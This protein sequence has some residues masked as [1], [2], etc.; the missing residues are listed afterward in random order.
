MDVDAASV[1]HPASS[2]AAT[3]HGQGGANP[4]Q[5]RP[6]DL[7]AGRPLHGTTDGRVLLCLGFTMAREEVNV[8]IVGTM[9]RKHLKSNIRLFE[10]QIP[11]SEVAVE[12]L[13]RRFDQLG[14][15]WEGLI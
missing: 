14:D 7:P 10:E 5:G 8:A 15:D 2:N 13:Y 1:A 9:N 12:E 3:S 4:R 11:I 6:T